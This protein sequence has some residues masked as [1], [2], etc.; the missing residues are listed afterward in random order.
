MSAADLAFGYPV[1]LAPAFVEW[2]MGLP[3][4]WVTDVP[5]LAPRPAGERNAMLSL[6]GDGVVPAQLAHGYRLALGDLAAS[7]A[8]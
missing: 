7:C 8:A 1:Q 3:Q 5:G 4:G 2:M 6:L